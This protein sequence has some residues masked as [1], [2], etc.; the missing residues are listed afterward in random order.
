[1]V[2]CRCI[3]FVGGRSVKKED[4]EEES[5]EKSGVFFVF[6]GNIFCSDDCGGKC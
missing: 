6:S 5:L 4:L 3:E 2:V 1:M